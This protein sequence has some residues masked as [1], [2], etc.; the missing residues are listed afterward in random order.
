MPEGRPAIPAELKRRVL[1]EAGHR[2]AIPTC[3]SVPVELAH[4]EPWARIRDHTF[5]NLIALC[6]TC[7]ARYDNG[8]I[9]T[10]SMKSYKANLGLV[11]G[12][13]G[14]MERRIL[15]LLADN[16]ALN[17]LRLPGGWDIQL[18]YLLKDGLIVK[19]AKGPTVLINGLPAT[20]D[21]IITHAGQEF[22]K[23]LIAAR[24]VSAEVHEKEWSSQ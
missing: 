14:E 17:Q 15:D 7:H 16:P 24:P 6:P 21:Y 12:R 10:L 11:S 22:I 2:C 20:E 4:I 19:A 13:Y 23:S 3:R 18:M 5:E 8:D 1:M 9:D